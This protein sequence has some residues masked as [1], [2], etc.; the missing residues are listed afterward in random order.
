MAMNVPVLVY[1]C[2]EYAWCL[3]PFL[4]LFD[5]YFSTDQLLIIGG[6]KP[7]FQATNVI[8][9]DVE[10]RTKERWSDGLI[11]CLNKIHE[12]FFVLMLEDF[13]ICRTI[14]H[15]AVGSLADYMAMNSDIFKIDLT[16]DRLCSGQAKDIGCW[17]RFDLIETS[18]DT[19]YQWSLQ[20]ALWNKKHLLDN[21]RQELSPWGFEL[22]D[23]RLPNL[24]ILGTRQWPLRYVNGVGM[25]LDARYKYRTIHTR[26]GV[27]GQT[28]EQIPKEHVD[29]MLA[30]GILPPGGYFG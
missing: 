22:Q 3:K 12:D 2:D 20:S 5:T 25:Q 18:W 9:L 6:C 30:N 1:T 24:H 11:D 26:N 15:Q 16:A 8:W 4:Y 10:S 21:L 13:W 23:K 29:I 14:D 17:G 19:Q 7:T 27:G 28:T